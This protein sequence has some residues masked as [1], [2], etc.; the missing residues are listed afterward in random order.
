MYI[1]T[2]MPWS[3]FHDPDGTGLTIGRLMALGFLVLVF[4]RIPS[5]LLTY[6]LMPHVV[7]DWKEALFMGYFGPIGAGA[8]FYVEHTRHLFPELGDGDEE[9]TNLVRAMIP[10]VYWL[11]LFSIVV[12]GFSI[13]ALNLV[14]TF[15]GVKPIQEDAVA[16]KRRSVRAP[17]PVNAEADGPDTIVAYNRFSRSIYNSVDLFQAGRS[18]F[19]TSPDDNYHHFSE[20]S[21]I[22]IEKDLAQKRAVRIMV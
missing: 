6:K 7:A 22:K 11:V 21:D 8:V 4:R 14:Y 17:T 20:E 15:M 12:H 19:N 10:A 13:P 9:E 3:D 18:Q 2:I 16:L 1:G 5:I